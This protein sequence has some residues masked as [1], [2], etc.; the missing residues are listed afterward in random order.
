RIDVAR[1][2]HRPA[3]AGAGAGA[4]AV[5]GGGSRRP[6]Q[7][8]MR[9]RAE[10]SLH[11]VVTRPAAP[12]PPAFKIGDVASR[13]EVRSPAVPDFHVGE[14]LA[15]PT[16]NLIRGDN[17][18]RRLEPQVMDL[19][20]FLAATDGR[21]VSKDEIIESVWDGRFIAEATLTRS[22][23]DLRRVLGD[24]QRSPRYIET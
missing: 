5:D 24:D 7:R 21:V 9:G 20:V 14:W 15:Q 13:K 4:G 16:L 11:S 3:V 2:P 6:R 19:L 22:V 23:A 17:V 12:R 10:S 18:V 8:R 1:G